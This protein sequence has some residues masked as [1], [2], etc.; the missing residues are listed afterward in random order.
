MAV[1]TLPPP[2][3]VDEDARRPRAPAWRDRLA[4]RA[5]RLTIAGLV[6]ALTLVSLYL[7]TGRLNFY[8]WIDEAISVGISSHPLAQLP[9]LLREDGSPPL[10]YALLHVWMQVF[11]HGEVATHWLSLA[12]AL[13]TVPVAYLGASSLF[14]RRTGA[15]SA[16]LAAGVP[17]LTTYA[18]ETRMYSLLVL[19]SLLV[20]ISFTHVFVL[21]HRRYLPLF[22][23]SLVAA[24]YT[25]NWALFEA[26]ATFLAFLFSVRM[27]PRGRRELW[28]DGVIGFGAV[29]VLFAPW[30][31]TLLYQAQHTGA[32]WALPP[33][34]WSLSQGF[35]F[36][37]GGRGAT[38][39]LALAA[40]VGLLATGT[41]VFQRRGRTLAIR[42]GEPG[43]RVTGVAVV[44]LAVLA[45]G[46]LLI[47]WL[48]AKTTPAWSWRYL[49]VI[50]G[51]LI[52]LVGL[53]LARARGLGIVALVLA[54]CFWVLDPAPTSRDAKSNVAS[55]AHVMSHR[56][57]AGTL[58]LSTQPEQVPDLAYYL[59]HLT[60]FATPLGAVPD[61]R[62]VDWRNALARFEH[63]S[64][65]TVLAPLIRGL[66]PGDRVLLVTPT[67]FAK[68]PEW[69]KLMHRDSRSWLHYLNHDPRL[70]LVRTAA[71]RQYS[72]NVA[73]RGYLYRVTGG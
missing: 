11:G 56:V 48:Y 66:A 5:N 53:G 7:R 64:V 25:H 31:P 38:M 32:P 42:S 46:T 44:S 47:A 60:R 71:P 36:I 27:T 17:F 43:E 45:F 16:V 4:P 9:H 22:S 8:Y 28:R 40:G 41:G 10:Y 30:L 29:A 18:Q 67:S 72:A 58:V 26:L 15:M 34:V 23:L 20:A 33:V 24:L 51:P 69:M 55:L 1:D 70:R 50:V 68:A 12:F 35:Y 59:P 2:A 54:C 6:L 14:G 57:G 61:P 19:L 49:G 62:V 13:I 63:S 39:T 65:P 21:R 73:V 52:V 37:G 3:P